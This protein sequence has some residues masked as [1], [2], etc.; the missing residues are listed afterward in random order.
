M[1]R[2]MTLDPEKVW[3]LR[4]AR[5]LSQPALAK[6]A[7]L[8]QSSVHRME[9]EVGQRFRW[10]EILKLAGALEVEPPALG[11]SEEDAARIA[12]YQATIKAVK[13]TLR[14]KP[15]NGAVRSRDGSVKSASEYRVYRGLS[16]Y[17]NRPARVAAAVV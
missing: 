12:H 8:G 15:P 1:A 17:R 4:E 3:A 11:V 10:R 9:T 14:K 13:R 6:K 5:G 7:K 16:G 2:S